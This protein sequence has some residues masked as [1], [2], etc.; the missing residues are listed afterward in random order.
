MPAGAEKRANRVPVLCRQGSS[1]IDLPAMG[2]FLTP[3][4]CAKAPRRAATIPP[5]NQTDTM[6]TS[7]DQD[8][9]NSRDARGSGARAPP[10]QALPPTPPAT[11]RSAWRRPDRDEPPRSSPLPD[12]AAATPAASPNEISP[13]MPFAVTSPRNRC[14]GSSPCLGRYHWRR[15][16]ASCHSPPPRTDLRAIPLLLNKPET[17]ARAFL[18]AP[19][20]K[21]PPPR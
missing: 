13:D 3:A 18:I 4:R 2:R 6:Q 16:A 10:R 19:C 11:T 21:D 17:P 8:R 12:P 9:A 5:R 1:G 15:P 20:L 7:A 14:G